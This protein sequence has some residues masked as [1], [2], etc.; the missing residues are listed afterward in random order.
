MPGEGGPACLDQPVDRGKRKILKENHKGNWGRRQLPSWACL[1]REKLGGGNTE[2][3]RETEPDHP[4]KRHRR[5]MAMR[6]GRVWFLRLIDAKEIAAT[7]DLTACHPETGGGGAWALGFWRGWGERRSQKCTTG[8]PGALSGY[9]GGDSGGTLKLL[10]TKLLGG[11][12][13]ASGS[14]MGEERPL[15]GKSQRMRRGGSRDNTQERP[16]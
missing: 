16:T 14:K 12:A 9:L 15:W 11:R 10:P 5:R 7:A 3:R 4:A 8:T 6:G 13:R 2:A 1:P